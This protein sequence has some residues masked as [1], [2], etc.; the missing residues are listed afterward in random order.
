MRAM[1]K[2]T[3]LVIVLAGGCLLAGCGGRS[4]HIKGTGD[5]CRQNVRVDVVGVNSMEKE[6][7]EKGLPMQDYWSESNPFRKESVD[8]SLRVTFSPG[9]PCEV[10]I[11]E[12]DPIW[13]KWKRDKATDF[14]V[15]FDTC[16]D[17]EAWYAC[18]PLSAKQWKGRTRRGTIEISILP[19]RV[20]PETTPKPERKR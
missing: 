20:K 13:R 11:K 8:Q 14:L 4:I 19:S 17:S 9:G 10:T 15:M 7:W 18:L 1:V 12:K 16:S 6:R 3:E 5:I 2:T